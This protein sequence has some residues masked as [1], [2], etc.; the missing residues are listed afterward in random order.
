LLREASFDNETALFVYQNRNKERSTAPLAV[1][2]VISRPEALLPSI[3]H[4]EPA[5]NR[6]TADA[7]FEWSLRGN[8]DRNIGVGDYTRRTEELSPNDPV[9]PDVLDRIGCLFV[10]ATRFPL[11]AL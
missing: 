1:V 3:R 11:I 7:S 9:K 6:R 5:S 4:I 8:V 2:I 10:N